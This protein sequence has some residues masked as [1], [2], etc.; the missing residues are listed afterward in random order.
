MIAQAYFDE[1]PIVRVFDKDGKMIA[2]LPMKLPPCDKTADD[3]LRGMKLRR[4]EP[5]VHASWLGRQ[6]K[7]RFGR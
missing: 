5:W 6:A 7:V 2:D 1:K 3:A 4:R